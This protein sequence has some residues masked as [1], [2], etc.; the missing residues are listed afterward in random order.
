M[1][2]V[3]KQSVSK[4]KNSEKGA[5]SDISVVI[6]TESPLSKTVTRTLIDLRDVKPKEFAK[7]V[8]ISA[9]TALKTLGDMLGGKEVDFTFDFKEENLP[10]PGC[11]K[12]TEPQRR[13][14][15]RNVGKKYYKEED[16][17]S[18][19]E[20]LYCDICKE[21]YKGSCPVHG[22]MLLVCDT[23]I[24]KGD[25][26][27]SKRTLP[28]FFSIGISTIPRAGLGVWT[29]IPLV[30]GTVFGP[31][32]GN[33]IKQN[34]D[35][36]K[37]GYAWQ[38]RK[39][40]KPHHYV[41]GADEDCSNWMRYVNC[42]DHEEWQSVVAFQYLGKIYY[43]TYKP[44]LPFTEILVWYGNSY[45]SE[46]GIELKGRKCLEPPKEITGFPCDVC[47]SLFSSSESLRSHRK[48]HPRMQHDGRHRCPECSYSTHIINHL[49]NH[50]L[51][52][53]GEKPHACPHCPKR[54][55][56]EGNLRTHLLLH[57]G[58]K[59]HACTTCGKRFTHKSN[60]L[61]H[62]RVHSGERPYRCPDCGKDFTQTSSLKR[63]RMLHTRQRPY[64]CPHCEHRST[65][66]S[67]LTRHIASRHTRVFP[68]NCSL[69]GKGFNRP[70]ELKKHAER[71][72]SENEN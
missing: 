60:L 66:S 17:P 59:E 25:A 72:H 13:Y 24:P 67:D 14:P 69:C 26:G 56:Q 64:P 2:A 68:H 16:V 3:P 40:S 61:T 27:R 22:P 6:E 7:S 41:E 37:S 36:K 9:E 58:Q 12:D 15:K 18:E 28:Y 34:D 44:V 65:C 4:C 70:G 62:E 38:V 19:D 71:Q 1:F 5:S 32:E 30:A 52:H 45:A 46:M 53:S 42:A 43:R 20:F 55:S 39:Q 48:T 49:R 21:E 47:N 31:Y 63:H 23:K 54:F 33:V 57:T 11:S 29:E 10:E 35:A 50:L 8:L 51:T